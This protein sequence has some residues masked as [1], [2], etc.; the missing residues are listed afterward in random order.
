M[1]TVFLQPNREWLWFLTRSL[2]CASSEKILRLVGVVTG[3]LRVDRNVFEINV[4]IGR[5]YKGDVNDRIPTL[6]NYRFPNF[7]LSRRVGSICL[8]K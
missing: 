1:L 8:L 6:K 5:L 2:Q 3:W 4:L 7:K